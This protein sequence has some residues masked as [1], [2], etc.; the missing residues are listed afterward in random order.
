MKGLVKRK[1]RKIVVKGFSNTLNIESAEVVNIVQRAGD[2]LTNQRFGGI[3]LKHLALVNDL[4]SK[5]AFEYCRKKGYI[6]QTFRGEVISAYHMRHWM[7]YS[8]KGTRK[9]FKARQNN[10][11]M[12][13]SGTLFINTNSTYFD[14]FV[15]NLR[16]NCREG[17]N[18]KIKASDFIP[19]YHELERIKREAK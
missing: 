19:P 13:K 4:N 10:L 18:T 9:A 15:K 14:K 2:T 1:S 3:S 17:Y 11:M 6:E 8:G 5:D 16:K 12:F 7:K